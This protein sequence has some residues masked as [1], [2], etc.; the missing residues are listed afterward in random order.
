MR[1][2]IRGKTAAALACLTDVGLLYQFAVLQSCGSAGNRGWIR[3]AGQ[4]PY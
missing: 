2:D 4:Q 1:H 3:A